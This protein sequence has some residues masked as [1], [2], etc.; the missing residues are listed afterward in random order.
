MQKTLPKPANSIDNISGRTKVDIKIRKE[1]KMYHAPGHLRDLFL[2][3]VE[4]MRMTPNLNDIL[5][6]EATEK[7]FTLEKIIGLLWNCTDTFPNI[8]WDFVQDYC[9]YKDFE[10]KSQ[11]YASCVRALKQNLIHV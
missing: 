6:N 9:A 7:K 2:E 10:P 8:Y 1:I 4:Q 3:Y 5:I 11:T